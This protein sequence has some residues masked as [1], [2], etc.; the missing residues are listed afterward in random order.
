MRQRQHR[1]G[2]CEALLDWNIKRLFKSQCRL[3]GALCEH[4]GVAFNR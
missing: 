2:V 3:S 4:K 1:V